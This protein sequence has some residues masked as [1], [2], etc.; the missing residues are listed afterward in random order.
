MLNQPNEQIDEIFKEAQA[1][2]YSSVEKTSSRNGII[3]IIGAIFFSV[4]L[5][6][7][8]KSLLGLIG[9]PL[10]GLLIFS[11]KQRNSSINGDSS[12]PDFYMPY[13]MRIVGELLSPEWGEYSCSME[14]KT[15]TI[16]FLS[17]SGTPQ[18]ASSGQSTRNPLLL[19]FTRDL[20]EDADRRYYTVNLGHPLINHINAQQSETRLHTDL[21]KRLKT[22]G[23]GRATTV[24]GIKVCSVRFSF[25][26]VQGWNFFEIGEFTLVR[27]FNFARDIAIC[28]TR[29]I[30]QT[31]REMDELMKITS[32]AQT[33]MP[34]M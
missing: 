15:I 29:I 13:I 11:A 33:P 10:L 25:D 21:R 12:D 7:M 3:C 8:L 32:S 19:Q 1:G 2:R 16:S 14:G 24:R 27:W 4:L 6:L 34:R 17:D 30:K 18:E 22:V 5:C 20:D 26:D 23:Y 9:G 31:E 28:T